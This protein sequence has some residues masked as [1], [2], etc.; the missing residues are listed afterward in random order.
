[1]QGGY[2][3]LKQLSSR[4]PRA[5]STSYKACESDERRSLGCF[6]TLISRGPDPL[7][8]SSYQGDAASTAASTR[9][10]GLGPRCE[11]LTYSYWKFPN[12]CIWLS[13]FPMS[14]C[15][16]ARYWCIGGMPTVSN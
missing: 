16:A 6:G 11:G 14:N 5:N 13:I 9:F 7:S 4:C 1:M 10:A 8:L 12:L 2:V 15:R 3:F